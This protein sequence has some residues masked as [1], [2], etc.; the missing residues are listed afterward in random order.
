[1]ENPV[2]KAIV[3]SKLQ[4]KVVKVETSYGTFDLTIFIGKYSIGGALAIQLMDT[5]GD[6]YITLT[7]NLPTFNNM[8][9]DDE[10]FIKNWTENEE[11]A[12]S[13]LAQGLFLDTCKSVATG[14]AL[15]PVWKILYQ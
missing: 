3:E 12:K 4:G 6:P 5:M 11:I 1:M 10:V 2:H 7:V 14:Y 15:A 13:L 9:A 8:L